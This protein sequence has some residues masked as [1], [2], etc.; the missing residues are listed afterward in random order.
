MLT[1]TTSLPA[2][3]S[4][5]R[6]ASST[7]ISSKGF[8]THLTPSVAKPVPSA[9][10]LSCVSGSGTRFT[11]TRIFT[12]ESPLG[13][14]R[15]EPGS[16]Q[17]SP[18]TVKLSGVVGGRRRPRRRRH[19]TPCT[20]PADR[21]RSLGAGLLSRLQELDDGLLVGDR[22]GKVRSADPD[23]LTLVRRDRVV[24]L[25]R[26]AVVQVRVGALHDP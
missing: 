22:Q 25:A 13:E 2:F 11:V 4:F 14:F 26:A 24:Q 23:R 9:L 8:T 18:M 10:I 3:F 21:R 20:P 7:A 6:S 15:T 16:V 12:G 5:R 17:R 19:R 1:S